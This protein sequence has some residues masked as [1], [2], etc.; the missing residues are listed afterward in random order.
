MAFLQ[1]QGA[2]GGG[3]FRE[4]ISKGGFDE[5]FYSIAKGPHRKG[6]ERNWE[7]SEKKE[8]INPSKR[9]LQG[10]VGFFSFSVSTSP[11][12]NDPSRFL[13]QDVTLRMYVLSQ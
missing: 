7:K 1:V 11:P 5:K 4:A 6:K 9:T 10:G 3:I 12:P 8:I 2:K 13:S